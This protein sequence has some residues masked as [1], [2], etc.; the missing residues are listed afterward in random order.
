M[1]KPKP[2]PPPPRLPSLSDGDEDPIWGDLFSRIGR[3]VPNR[4]S[5]AE[6][7]AVPPLRKAKVPT[8]TRKPVA[9]LKE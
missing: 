2:S 8:R 1:P 6:P 9:N 4:A 7:A 5:E 3:P